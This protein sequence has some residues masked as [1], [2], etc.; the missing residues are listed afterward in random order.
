MMKSS[1]AYSP[2]AM[3]CIFAM[4]TGLVGCDS[5]DASSASKDIPP[6]VIVETV[7]AT[8]LTLI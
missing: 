7:T 3:L 6:D 1:V 5:K 4:T 8:P 2:L